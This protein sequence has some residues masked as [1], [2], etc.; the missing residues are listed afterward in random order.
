MCHVTKRKG[1]YGV[2]G[3][4]RSVKKTFKTKTAAKAKAKAMRGA[5]WVRAKKS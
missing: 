4:G 3:G 5:R 1:G 2:A